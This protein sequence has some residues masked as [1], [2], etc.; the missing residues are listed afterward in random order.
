MDAELKQI[1]AKLSQ[2]TLFKGVDEEGILKVLRLS[3]LKKFNA[4][5]KLFEKGD[6]T[7]DFWILIGG[8]VELKSE[9]K[10]IKILTGP[11]IIGELGFFIKGKNHSVDAVLLQDSVLIK[12]PYGEF[13]LLF[14]NDVVLKSYILSNLALIISERLKANNQQILQL[15]KKLSVSPDFAKEILEPKEKEEMEKAKAD[16][17]LSTIQNPVFAVFPNIK[18]H[19]EVIRLSDYRIVFKK[20]KLADV[21]TNKIYKLYLFCGDKIPL[22]A[23]LKVTRQVQNEVIAKWNHTP[24]DFSNLLE[25]L[26]KQQL[27]AV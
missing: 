14:R 19:G 27:E 5:E 15:M 23:E 4:G 18:G 17:D 24:K 12:M 13:N 22:Q 16:I 11:C 20:N 8:R 10:I 21:E 3:K 2:L 25:E 6:P 1:I 9:K 26:V 7:K